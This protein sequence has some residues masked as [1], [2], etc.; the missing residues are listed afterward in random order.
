MKCRHAMVLLGITLPICIALKIIQAVFTIDNKTG[1]IKQNYSA[2]GM[3]ITLI[4]CATI[5]VV[6]LIA[7]T[8]RNKPN[9]KS[10]ASPALAVAS[11][12]LG[13]IF[14]YQTVA[15]MSAL[16]G[17]WYDIFMIIL[18]VFSAIAFLAYGLKNIYSYNMPAVLM[19]V[20]TVYYVIKLISLFISKSKLALVT[21]N[22]FTLFTN[23]A[24]LLFLFELACLENKIGDI[25]KRQKN[26]FG[27][28]VA[29][30]MLC[31]TTAVA[32]FA[33]AI[34]TTQKVFSGDISESLLNLAMAIFIFV[35]I[36]FNYKDDN[37]VLE[38]AAPKHQ[39]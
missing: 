15:G 33:V 5:A 18:S 35:Y 29:T 3:L 26:L 22:A 21:D 4:V 8:S 28:G 23:C 9:E 6:S 36:V 13:G 25:P 39:A 19:T 24:L 37:T 27:Y 1:F 2:V 32:K 31:A 34:F 30:V 10:A 17:N 16:N 14:I 20:P 12:L 38:N 7:F 11:A